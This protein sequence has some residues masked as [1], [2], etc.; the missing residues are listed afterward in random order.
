MI[1]ADTVKI[2]W[3]GGKDSTCA[4]YKHIERDDN[5]KAVCYIPYFTDDI[6]LI[7][8][9][10]FDFIIRQKECFEKQGAIIFLTKGLTYWDYCFSVAKSGIFKGQVKGYPYIGFCGFRRDSKIKACSCY[11]GDY[12]YES[13]GIA[14]DEKARHNQLN[15]RK[16]SILVEKKI[17]EEMA[18]DFCLERNAYSP[19]YKY[20]K[21]DG[22]ALCFNAKPMELKIW[23]NDYPQ[24]RG[25][26]IELQEKMKPLLISRKNEYPLR[27]YK[28]FI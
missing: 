18:K 11:V 17:T 12:D 10:H 5:I 22:C 2:G 14:F 19:H 13:L 3:S 26:L 6:P 9:E 24:A 7:N 16:R 23:L 1:I 27:G 20:S 4:M 21:R 15:E 25:K 28:Y 8:K